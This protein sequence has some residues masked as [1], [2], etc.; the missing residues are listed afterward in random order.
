MAHGAQT[1]DGVGSVPMKEQ[2]S[3]LDIV[4]LFFQPLMVLLKRWDVNQWN[5]V[6]MGGF[7]NFRSWG[8]S[9][10]SG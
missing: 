10:L 4:H 3:M 5:S 7:G 2:I 8:C 1:E 9:V 6:R